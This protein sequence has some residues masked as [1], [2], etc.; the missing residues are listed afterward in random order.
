MEI[1]EWLERLK[2]GNEIILVNA[3]YNQC[4]R[5]LRCD[6]DTT[7]HEFRVEDVQHKSLHSLGLNEAADELERL[8]QRESRADYGRIGK[9]RRD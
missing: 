9:K 6:D 7:E 4:F 3:A 8:I 1:R 2:R 5:V